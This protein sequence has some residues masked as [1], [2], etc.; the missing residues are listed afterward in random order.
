MDARSFC[1]WQVI[2]IIN[3]PAFFAA[4]WKLVL[5]L[6]PEPTQAKVRLGGTR[7][8]AA[9]FDE[10]CEPD[11]VPAEY[12]GTQVGSP[13]AHPY[14]EQFKKMVYALNAKKGFLPPFDGPPKFKG[15]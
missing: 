13:F 9:L 10:F 15:V 8:T 7:D 14:E 5:P 4:I 6:L 12:G 2:L 1:F 11:Q 3:A